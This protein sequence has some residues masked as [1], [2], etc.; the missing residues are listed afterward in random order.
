MFTNPGALVRVLDVG[1]RTASPQG[2]AA[3]HMRSMKG[4]VARGG[5]AHIE[6]LVIPARRRHED[7]GLVPRHH[8]ALAP[9]GGPQYRVAIACRNDDHYPRPVMVGL[10]VAPGRED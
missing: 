10:L 3:V 7:A 1:V 9:A 8:D 6:V 5:R 4:Q 2:I